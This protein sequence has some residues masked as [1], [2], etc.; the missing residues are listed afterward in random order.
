MRRQRSVSFYADTQEEYMEE[1]KNK[2]SISERRRCR[3]NSYQYNNSNSNDISKNFEYLQK[4]KFFQSYDD[5]EIEQ[6]GVNSTYQLAKIENQDIEDNEGGLIQKIKNINQLFKQNNNSS[7]FSNLTPFSK[8]IIGKFGYKKNK[9]NEKNYKRHRSNPYNM[10]DNIN[11]INKNL[12]I[13]K[14]EEKENE[15]EKDSDE[16]DF[17]TG[18]GHRSYQM[19]YLGLKNPL[20]DSNVE[21]RE[22]IN[23][24]IENKNEETSFMDNLNINELSNM[25]I[26]GNENNQSSDSDLNLKENSEI[27]YYDNPNEENE[28]IELKKENSLNSFENSGDEFELKSEKSIDN[29]KKDEKL[30]RKSTFDIKAFCPNSGDNKEEGNKDIDQFKALQ[31]FISNNEFLSK[32]IDYVDEHLK[33]LISGTDIYSKKIFLNQLLNTKIN[34]EENI[35]ESINIIK[36]VIKLLGDYIKLELYEDNCNLCY[37][38]MLQTYVDFS[39]GIIL[40]INIENTNSAKYIYDII[41]KLKYKI[42]KDKRHFSAIL[43]CFYLI[44]ENNKE[45]KNKEN[46]K[47]INNDVYDIINKIY[48][49]FEIKPNYINIDINNN[50]QKNENFKF[51]INKYLSLA[52]LKKERKRKPKETKKTHKRGMT[53]L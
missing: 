32:N 52:Y 12:K 6:L 31:N 25:Q 18:V 30:T 34:H 29:T 9:K 51:I 46:L 26:K 41:D 15:D 44:K 36:K 45:I 14:K 47:E 33:F 50:K 8:N 19:R 3:S 24:I 28:E 38:H 13:N 39:D 20:E 2:K 27:I 37:N 7:F 35:S 42:N 17:L 16:E 53:G 5:L 22:R 48:D 43:I 21:K 49:D 40:I 1:L 11:N 10:I 23:S 4:K